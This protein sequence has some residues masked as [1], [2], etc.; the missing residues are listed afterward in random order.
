MNPRRLFALLAALTGAVLLVVRLTDTGP[1]PTAAPTPSTAVTWV[2]TPA[3]TAAATTAS[4]VTAPGNTTGAVATPGNTTSAAA[5]HADNGD[6]SPY[7]PEPEPTVRRADPAAT[8]TAFAR[9]W[10][11][12]RGPDATD[13]TRRV[14]ALATPT[15]AGK[16]RDVDPGAVPADTVAGTPTITPGMTSDWADA[17]VDTNAGTLHL[18]LLHTDKWRVATLD[19][20]PT[21]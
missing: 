18:T 10:T 8:A 19:W 5:G 9:A 16:L 21:R 6:D 4:E 13:W 17:T 20:T 7:L 12:H 11:R 15:L 1:A 14:S 3:P 2:A